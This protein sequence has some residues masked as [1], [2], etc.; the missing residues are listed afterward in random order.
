[1]RPRENILL[2][3]DTT[4]GTGGRGQA[5]GV[6]QFGK[7]EEHRETLRMETLRM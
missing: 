4:P 2:S 5:T 7:G 3:S 6:G 1:M